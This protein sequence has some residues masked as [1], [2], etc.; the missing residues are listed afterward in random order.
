MDDERPAL[1]PVGTYYTATPSSPAGVS[2]VHF[3]D[4]QELIYV[5][6][7]Q[8]HTRTFVMPACEPYTAHQAFYSPIL[9]WMSD[10]SLNR[11]AIAVSAEGVKLVGRRGMPIWTLTAKNDFKSANLF[12]MARA[13]Q[14]AAAHEMLVSAS[15][16]RLCVVNYERGA[17]LRD[18]AAD[19]MQEVHVMCGAGAHT[20]V[21]GA[22]N[23]A[24]KVF[25]ARTW[26]PTVSLAVQ[27]GPF[28]AVVAASEHLILTTGAHSARNVV[29]VIDLRTQ[30]LLGSIPVPAALLTAL[31]GSDARAV[32]IGEAGVASVL[33]AATL[34]VTDTVT[35]FD[36]EAVVPIGESDDDDDGDPV[37]PMPPSYSCV[38]ASSS[39][40]LVAIGD[41][42]G[43]VHFWS[44]AATTPSVDT[45]SGILD[46]TPEDAPRV[47]AVSEP[48]VVPSMV[49]PTDPVHWDPKVALNEFGMPR[50]TAP[51]LSGT[52][53]EHIMHSVGLPP[54]V[55][56]PSIMTNARGTDALKS[57][58]K[59]AS[60]Q[61]NQWPY[62]TKPEVPRF[63]SARRNRSRSRGRS[64][65]EG[66]S[67]LDD[68]KQMEI[69]YSRFG[70]QDFDFRFFNPTPYAGLETAVPQSYVNNYLQALFYAR[71]FAQCAIQH[72]VSPTCTK[73][74]CLL[75]ET[76]YL[77]RMLQQAQGQEIVCRAANWCST[78]G[79][80][81]ETT[82]MN[83]RENP[84]VPFPSI[85]G[86]M[87]QC[88]RFLF[89]QFKRDA[90]S[91]A[92]VE[93]FRAR[94][95]TRSECAGCHT[96]KEKVVDAFTVDLAY[97]G[98]R[99]NHP[100]TTFV[101]L[102]RASMVT[103][104]SSRVWCSKCRQYKATTQDRAP[105]RLPNVLHV[106]CNVRTDWNSDWWCTKDN[107]FTGVQGS[108]FMPLRVKIWLDDE[109]ALQ[110]EQAAD[111]ASGDDIYALAA[112]V[113]EVS[114]G[115]P[116]IASH[117]E[118]EENQWYM[119]NDFL[120]RHIPENQVLQFPR[121]KTPTI[122][123]YRRMV[124]QAPSAD[125]VM[126][127]QAGPLTV[128]SDP[129]MPL[130]PIITP[131]ELVSILEGVHVI[132]P[133]RCVAT[134]DPLR[135]GEVVHPGFLCAIDAEFVSLQEEEAEYTS[136][137]VKRVTRPARLSLARVS[138]VRGSGARAGSVCID[139]Y[140][141]Q[142]DPVVDYVTAYS[143]IEPSDLDHDVSTRHLVPLKAAYRRLRCM[144]DAGAVFV[145]HSLE[146]D[147][148][149][150]N[151]VVSPDQVVDTVKL[152]HLPSQ[153]RKLSL[154][155]LAWAALGLH[156]QVGNH[157]SVE[158]ARTA[159]ALYNKYLEMKAVGSW[160]DFLLEI[161]DLGHRNAFRPP[162]APAHSYSSGVIGGG[163]T[164]FVPVGGTPMIPL[165]MAGGGATVY[166]AAPPLAN[167]PGATMAAVAAA[168]VAPLHFP[169][170]QPPSS[171]SGQHVAA[172]LP[173]QPPQ[174]QQ[175]R[176]TPVPQLQPQPVP[177]PVQPQ[178]P[179]APNFAAVVAGRAM[180]SSNRWA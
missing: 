47:N 25:D 86:T 88:A 152:Y 87:A 35:L 49:T 98:A 131:T 151:L 31:P 40:D 36:P 155:F 92:V 71:G 27:P 22:A 73:E 46:W 139:D 135:A 58:P 164:E 75:C 113:F 14:S 28:S 116:H 94:L 126:Y 167:I 158:D 119:F 157:D 68:Y 170:P 156:V 16:A 111:D 141:E 162:P 99:I 117:V 32:A 4:Y 96:R 80:V 140:I 124:P 175:Q 153:P 65:G 45:D 123:H 82:V 81:R 85:G 79:H 12:A 18:L 90:D 10:S 17:I 147:F 29:D 136:D 23:G 118:V 169:P 144:A 125:G 137:G 143:G 160:D 24:L 20:V 72:S 110:I 103:T 83:L 168:A 133:T 30:A 105:I 41:W 180:P 15:F 33:D 77:F 173:I 102:L 148:R 67:I 89:D 176:A 52:W 43:N 127:T 146:Q 115:R 60:L 104:E 122:L 21:A 62:K 128:S 8:G 172:A 26:R 56:A 97:P 166:A 59:P 42:E 114:E 101:D 51:L 5:G 3:D 2:A 37:L 108:H 161:Y 107:H 121:W 159:L 93:E 174:M 74:L 1:V 129:D 6:H 11:G 177:A 38:H 120:V 66:K 112:V 48:T 130:D 142:R 138:V 70:V 165:G 84:A 178:Q 9:G 109:Q 150:I 53:P 132:N 19:E 57:A 44:R 145:G 154:K 50:Y 63:K 100:D 7:A 163:S 55:I 91:V 76:G 34:S 39:G 64:A 171:L 134:M 69:Q 54:V 61:R 179:R 95:L 13:P 149:I 106:N 78:F